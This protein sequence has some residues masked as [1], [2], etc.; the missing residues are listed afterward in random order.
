MPRVT[1]QRYNIARHDLPT[2]MEDDW[3]EISCHA[4]AKRGGFVI[5]RICVRLKCWR[6]CHDEITHW[7][8]RS[9]RWRYQQ[10]S[11]LLVF[12]RTGEC[13]EYDLTGGVYR[14]EGGNEAFWRWGYAK[15]E[16]DGDSSGW[17]SELNG[18]DQ[19]VLKTRWL[20]DFLWRGN[21]SVSL[22]H[23][24]CGTKVQERRR[25]IMECM[26][27]HEESLLS[28]CHLGWGMKIVCL[29]L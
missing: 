29:R 6:L 22:V 11:S 26:N 2:L 19:S 4:A 10:C 18:D 14:D 8:C 15:T 7:V 5:R 23:I 12:H 25:C 1:Q 24:L 17:C 9:Y 27:T 16:E 13:W 21:V 20:Q 3:T 28:Q